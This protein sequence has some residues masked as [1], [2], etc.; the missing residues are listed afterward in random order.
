[1]HEASEDKFVDVLNQRIRLKKYATR[2]Q[3]LRKNAGFS[4]KELAEKAEVNLRTL[5]QYE[6][7]A[8]D[9]NKAAAGTLAAIARV[10]SCRVEDLLERG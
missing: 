6:I 10:L 4:Q 7:R 3:V 1:M 5:Q 9:I 8:K 2:L